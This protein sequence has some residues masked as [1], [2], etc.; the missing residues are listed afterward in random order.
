M[1]PAHILLFFGAALT[2]APAPAQTP[3]THYNLHE[4]NFDLWC[5]ET[6]HY[7]PD[8][9]DKRLPEDDKEFQAYV[10]TIEKY[11]VPYLQ[12]KRNQER[13]DRTILHGD[14]IDN[15]HTPATPQTDPTGTPQP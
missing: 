8:R 12:N 7:P 15:P 14:P 11:E 4:M 9:C 5:Q 1:R 6:K 10:G 13:Q 2:A 3:P